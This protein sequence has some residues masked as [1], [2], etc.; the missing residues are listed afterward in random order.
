[1]IEDLS[2]IKSRDPNAVF[3]VDWGKFS[4]KMTRMVA[5][6]IKDASFREWILP[7]FT[8][9]TKDDQTIASIIMMSTLQ[10][11]FT[12][13]CR[14]TCGLPSVN[15]LGEKSDWEQILSKIE[16]LSTFGD[17]PT[18]WLTLLRP[19]I[20]HFV[21]S[22]DE[23]EGE[24][25]KNFWQKIVHYSGGGS[26]RTYL[27][28]WITA[29]CFWGSEG[30]C[31]R[32]FDY[33][34]PVKGDSMRSMGKPT[35][36]LELDDARYHRIETDQVPPGTASVPVKLYSN[37]RIVTETIMFAGSL[38]ISVSQLIPITIFFLLQTTP[39]HLP[40]FTN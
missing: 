39:C 14:I 2:D 32:R 21:A 35:P 40:Y 19:V 27:S 4:F 9:T 31:Y 15:L 5:E 23:P 28:G 24:E 30:K 29:F 20:R 26:G 38:G 34:P 36:V 13:G 37:M 7:T 10:K 18:Q 11:Y 3:G 25:V 8:T 6:N 16:R 1:M 22:F 17:E 12:Y 33:N